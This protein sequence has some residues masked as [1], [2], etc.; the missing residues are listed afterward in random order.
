MAGLR[1]RGSRGKWGRLNRSEPN[2]LE[3]ADAGHYIALRL[4]FAYP[5]EEVNALPQAWVAHYS[6]LRLMLHDPLMHWVYGNTGVIRWSALP[7]PDPLQVLHQAQTFGLRYGIS[8]SVEDK[9]G[10]GQRSFGH[11]AVLIASSWRMK[12]RSASPLFSSCTMKR[13]RRAI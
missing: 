12:C 2:L 13:R 5:L 10:G 3:L 4:G 1:Y 7:G 6:K 11:F 9:S 8:V